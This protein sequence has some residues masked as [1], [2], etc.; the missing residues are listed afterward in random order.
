MTLKILIRKHQC[1]YLR[2]RVGKG[3][4]WVRFLEELKK[5]H[6]YEVHLKEY[7]CIRLQKFE[8]EQ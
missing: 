4:M 3:R 7:V 8:I 5:K 2:E 1:S 6:E